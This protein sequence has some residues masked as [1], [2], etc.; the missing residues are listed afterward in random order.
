MMTR[1]HSQTLCFLLLLALF[2][3]SAAVTLAQTPPAPKPLP[4][5]Q[6]LLERAK[7][8]LETGHPDEAIRLAQQALALAKE[9][10]DRAG[11]GIALRRIGSINNRTGQ[12]QNARE[13]DQQ[14]LA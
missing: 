6:A 13:F 8:A 4:E 9:H 11:E 3:L 2:C 1:Q 14:A 7:A 12:P 5:V 10:K